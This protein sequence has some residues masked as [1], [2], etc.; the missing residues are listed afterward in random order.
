[1][2]TRKLT[3]LTTIAAILAVG[4]LGSA[5][6]IWQE[7]Y[8]GSLPWAA[9]VFAVFFL[10]ATWLLGRGRTTAGTVFA[11]LLCLFEVVEFPSWPKH[12]ALDW[13]YQTTLA[14]VSLA[15]LIAAIAV[16][17]DRIRHR[18]AA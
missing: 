16:L 10:T 9:V 12:N 13:T 11:G 17:A 14:L 7:N 4:E 1:M 8:P 5:I 2:K 6:M 18:A 15:G 3:I